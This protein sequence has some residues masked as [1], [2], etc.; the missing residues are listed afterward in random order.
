MPK[1][2]FSEEAMRQLIITKESDKFRNLFEIAK[3]NQEINAVW[4]ELRVDLNLIVNESF[5]ITQIKNKMKHLKSKWSLWQQDRTVTGNDL[6]TKEKEPL[7]LDLMEEYWSE[8]RGLNNKPLLHSDGT[9]DALFSDP[10]SDISTLPTPKRQK[11]HPITSLG[12][13]VEIG[14]NRMSEGLV[15]AAKEM[16][17]SVNPSNDQMLLQLKEAV[18][19]STQASLKQSESIDKLIAFLVQ[20]EQ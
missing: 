6:L 5:T 13:S 7:C 18:E 8:R 1:E 3:S 9:G 12:S 20:K 17:K 19:Q 11:I 14:L 15:L 16:S 2:L 10:E 4:E